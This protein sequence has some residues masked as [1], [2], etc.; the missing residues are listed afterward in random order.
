MLSASA[1][2]AAPSR[3]LVSHTLDDFATLSAWS[4]RR[5]PERIATEYSQ[6]EMALDPDGPTGSCFRLS[7]ALRAPS[8]DIWGD[9]RIEEPVEALGPSVQNVTRH[10]ARLTVALVEEDGSNYVS[11][12]ADLDSDGAWH[13]LSFPVKDFTEAP[14]QPDENGR[15]DFPTT[16]VVL[17]VTGV[18]L[19][20]PTTLRLANLTT[21]SPRPAQ[22]RLTDLAVLPT[23]EA[24]RSLTVS[25][26]LLALEPVP[27]APTRLQLVREGAVIASAEVRDPGADLPAG[28]ATTLGALRIRIPPLAWGGFCRLV[29]RRPGAQV[30]G[31]EDG[32]LTTVNVVPRIPRPVRYSVRP[33]NGTPQLFADD[34]PI[35]SAAYMYERLNPDEV[36]RFARAGVHLYWLE[37]RQ[38]GWVGPERF[39]FALID[40]LLA[41]LFRNDP[42][43]R[44]VLWFYVDLSSPLVDAKAD[45]WQAAHPDELCRDAAGKGW[46]NYGHQAVSLASEAWR[47][48]ATAAM[49][50]FIRR[51]EGSPFADR[52]VGYQP[53]AGISYEWMYVGGHSNVFLDYSA[54]AVRAF[55][56]WLRDQYGG[57]VARLRVA[58]GSDAVTFATAAIPAPAEREHTTLGCLRDPQA[59][60]PVTDY[61]TF[62]AELTAGTIDHFCHAIKR[63]T[64]GAKV[65]GAFYGYV[66]EQAFVHGG[67]QHTGHFALGRALASDAIDFLMSPT[68][69]WAREPGEPGAHMTALGSVRLHGKLW[70]NQADLRTHLSPPDA[71]FGRSATVEQSL[72]VMRRE[73]AMDLA[74]GV[75]VYWYSFSAPWFGPSG[76]LMAGVHQMAQIAADADGLGRGLDGDGLAVIVS[77]SVAAHTGLSYQ[78]LRALV[79]LQRAALHRSGIRFDVFL[80]SDLD[81]PRLPRYKA[82]LFLDAV[83]LTAAQRRWI[84]ANLKR[85]GQVLAFAWAQGISGETLS[86]G[87]A[88]DLCGVRLGMDAFPGVITIQ[89]DPGLG[90]QYGG[91]EPF[92]PVLFADDPDAT[93]LGRL[94]S[95]ATVAGRVG[96]CTRRF[97]GWTSVYSAAPTL[98][99]EVIRMI[100]GLAGIHVWSESNDP[101]YVGSHFVGIHAPTAGTRTLSLPAPSTV[102]DCFTG[103]E[104]GRGTERFDVDLG[105]AETAVYRIE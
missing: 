11:S 13:R 76:A 47:Q 28:A 102:V 46:D 66:M 43:A 79:Y 19:G 84:D 86:L 33:R 10:A 60:R 98:S 9:L 21:E 14:W 71:G 93:T 17:V 70:L 31:H 100:A 75:P 73:F 55:R 12:P 105:A 59:E 3:E 29:F 22:L 94:T 40:E 50:H 4:T 24:G 97:P 82:Y 64:G 56:N 15:L 91:E 52:I 49:G 96:L 6:W 34:A 16:F 87:N 89:P 48:D 27:A 61:Y 80:D 104:V 99:P 8:A 95:P 62:M 88:Q 85:D 103:R 35:P 23:V 58:W 36:R 32:C 54:P 68:S 30:V 53:C 41:D 83:H 25:A 72:G 51:M 57:E 44:V 26:S 18:E 67:A 42:Q 2:P 7:F 63:A 101:I 5:S 37:C 69:Y 20:L 90:P 74:A 39:D 81:N 38:M 78:P 1:L 92:G 45:W 77:D 65:A